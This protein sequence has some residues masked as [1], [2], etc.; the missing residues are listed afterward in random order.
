MN[1]TAFELRRTMELVR[2]SFDTSASLTC[3]HSVVK[4][5]YFYSVDRKA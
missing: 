4:A 2:S 3:A 5:A 1:L